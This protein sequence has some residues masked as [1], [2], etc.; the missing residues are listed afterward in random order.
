MMARRRVIHGMVKGCAHFHT[1]HCVTEVFENPTLKVGFLIGANGATNPGNG[2]G[3]GFLVG[4]GCCF[5]PFG[6]VVDCDQDVPVSQTRLPYWAHNVDTHSLFD[7]A[8]CNWL[9]RGRIKP[10]PCLSAIQWHAGKEGSQPEE[11][12][13][14]VQYIMSGVASAGKLGWK[15]PDAWLWLLI[16]Q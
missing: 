3:V 14:E 16:C 11:D 9:K 15:A 12:M 7:I 2:N 1:A 8:R 6:E 5:H 4:K 10:K 13:D